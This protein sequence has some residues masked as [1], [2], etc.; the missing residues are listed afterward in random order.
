MVVVAVFQVLSVFVGLREYGYWGGL[1]GGGGRGMMV[2]ILVIVALQ[3]QY[4]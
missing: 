1:G 3:G 2:A 4:Q